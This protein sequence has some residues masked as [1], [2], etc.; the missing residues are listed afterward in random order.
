MTTIL[1]GLGREGRAAA[2]Y[3]TQHVEGEVLVV[4]DRG[5]EPTP[6]GTIRATRTEA[7]ER[8]AHGTLLLRSPGIPPD[9]PFLLEAIRRGAAVTTPTGHYLSRHAPP[10]TVTITGTKGKSTTTA[11]TAAVL[12]AGGLTAAAYGNIGAPPLGPALPAEAHPVVEV[13]SYMCHDL[14]PPADGRWWR[15]HLVTNLHKEHT[16]W[17]GS[18]GAYRATK[19]RPYRLDPPCPGLAPRALIEAEGLPSVVRPFEDQV[20]VERGELVIANVPFDPDEASALPLLGAEGTRS[21]LHAALRDWRGLPSRQAVVETADG[22]LWVD[23]ALATVPEAAMHALARFGDRPVRLVLG[24]KDRGQALDRLVG[25]LATLPDGRAFGFGEVS[26][27][28]EG[29]GVAVH[30]SMEDAVRA[31]AADCPEGG[32]VLFSPAAPSGHPHRNYEERSALFAALAAGATPRP[33]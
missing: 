27:Q 1:Y 10:G 6:E 23:D 15:A 25:H 33:Q 12:R 19:L 18:E 32:V 29:L 26:A 24:G 13:S 17:H 21:A 30:P 22:R 31:A 7:S 28:L 8:I 14:P 4:E 5:N 3:L 9:D 16:D 2:G 11:L 20:A